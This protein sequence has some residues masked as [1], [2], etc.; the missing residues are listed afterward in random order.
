MLTAS[1]VHQS[2]YDLMERF[3]ELVDVLVGVLGD[4]EPARECLVAPRDD[5][6]LDCLVELECAERMV[7]LV[8]RGEAQGVRRLRAVESDTGYVVI[9][10]KLDMLELRVGLADVVTASRGSSITNMLA[11]ENDCVSGPSGKFMLEK[12]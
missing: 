7:D 9:D 3:E 5:D 12:T 2:A 11:H 1:S 4:V 6:D 8:Q 10:P